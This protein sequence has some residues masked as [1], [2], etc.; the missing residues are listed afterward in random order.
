MAFFT[1]QEGHGLQQVGENLGPHSFE[2]RS[3]LQELFDHRLNAPRADVSLNAPDA[4]SR[5]FGEGNASAVLQSPD[6]T[7]FQLVD[8]S[9]AGNVGDV[10]SSLP[11]DSGIGNI[12]DSIGSAI[13]DFAGGG[14]PAGFLS[15]LFQFLM[16]LFSDGM[17]ELAGQIDQSMLG[18][19][20]EATKKLKMS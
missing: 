6:G 14:M 1:E 12:Q 3:L 7:D 8:S 19:A 4:T 5:F 15:Q 16:N 11:T 18:A 17:N 20:A 13:G 2:H 9:A 10:G